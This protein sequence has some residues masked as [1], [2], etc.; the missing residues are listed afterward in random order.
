MASENEREFARL[1]HDGPAAVDH[2]TI[3]TDGTS[4]AVTYLD[5]ITH[6]MAV[7]HFSDLD[8]PT[9]YGPDTRFEIHLT[10]DVRI[11]N[12]PEDEDG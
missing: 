12:E 11:I 3:D 2:I 1:R 8:L 6:K 5:P 9:R 4:V 7:M 10:A